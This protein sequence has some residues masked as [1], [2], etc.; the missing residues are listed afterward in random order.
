MSSA[1]ASLLLPLDSRLAPAP[2]SQF[3]RRH[4]NH[5]STGTGTGT[6]TSSRG[7]RRETVISSAHSNRSSTVSAEQ[8]SASAFD[9]LMLTNVNVVNSGD[10]P[11]S[12][13]ISNIDSVVQSVTNATKR[14]SQI[15][16]ITNNS[17]KKRKTQNRVGPWKLGRTL[18]RGSTG[19]VRLAKNVHTGKLA[20]VKIVP[21]SNFKKLENPKYKRDGQ[22]DRLPYGIEREIIIM[23]LILHPNIMGLYDVWENK[24]DLYL[25]L[26][27]IEGGELFDYLIKRGKLN[28]LEAINYFKQ[29]INGISYLHQFNICHRD[30]KPE[31]LLLDFDKVIKIADFGMAALEVREKLLETSCGSPHYA[32]PEIVAGKNYHGAP[33]DIW[34]CGIILFAL[35]TGHLP[36][37][38][39]NIR[40][41]LI[42]VQNGKFLMPPELSW[43]A[44]DLISKMLK[45]NP[46]DRITIDGILK[47]PLLTKYP[48]PPQPRSKLTNNGT[49]L[50][51]ID[52]KR[53]NLKPID[54]VDL[55]DKEILKNL[56]VLFHNCDEQ[57]IIKKLLSPANCSEK[58]FYFLLMK[59]RNEHA[60]SPALPNTEDGFPSDKNQNQKQPS[61]PKSASVTRTTLVDH[62]TGDLKTFITSPPLDP[63]PK[64]PV[65]TKSAGYSPTKL[66]TIH[67][68]HQAKT[69]H[70]T[71][72]VTTNHASPSKKIL[73]N[74]TNTVTTTASPTKVKDPQG[75]LSFKASNSFNK[76]KIVMKKTGST[77]TL[78]SLVN[79]NVNLL[80]AL[81]SDSEQKNEKEISTTETQGHQQQKGEAQDAPPTK[82]KIARDMTSMS[83][84]NFGRQIEDILEGREHEELKRQS[85]VLL[86]KQKE[87]LAKLQGHRNVTEPI[88]N[89]GGLS[90]LDPRQNSL[91][92]A[93]TYTTPSYASLK[94]RNEKLQDTQASSV[95]HKLGIDLKGSQVLRL[96]ELPD[97]I[98]D[99]K[100]DERVFD[101]TKFTGKSGDDSNKPK[102]FD[103]EVPLAESSVT[104]EPPAAPQLS[105]SRFSGALKTSSSRN[106]S[107]L[108]K[109]LEGTNKESQATTS[110]ESTKGSAA[111]AN[112]N[113]IDLIPNVRFSRFSMTKFLQEAESK[114]LMTSVPESTT[115]PPIESKSHLR[116]S[117][118]A[119]HE[120]QFVVVSSESGMNLAY[121]DDSPSGI[122]L[123]SETGTVVHHHHHSKSHLVRSTLTSEKKQDSLGLGIGVLDSSTTGAIASTTLNSSEYG[124]SF[125][126]VQSESL[127]HD[128][129]TSR[130]MANVVLENLNSTSYGP[131]MT[132]YN[133]SHHSKNKSLVEMSH[134][135]MSEFTNFD[136]VS[137][138]NI[139][140]GKLNTSNP[141]VVSSNNNSREYLDNNRNANDS[142]NTF[143]YQPTNILDEASLSESTLN[144][145]KNEQLHSALNSLSHTYNEQEEEEEEEDDEFGDD[146]SD[147]DL[148][149]DDLH[150]H[151]VVPQFSD[152]LSFTKKSGSQQI[153]S[154]QKLSLELVD[155]EKTPPRGGTKGVDFNKEVIVVD[156]KEPL[157]PPVSIKK[158]GTKASTI[159]R[160]L[161]LK[162]KRNAPPKPQHLMAAGSP[163]T[164]ISLGSSSGGSENGKKTNRF[165]RISVTSRVGYDPNVPRKTNWF[166]K[167]FNSLTNSPHSQEMQSSEASPMT[168][169]SRGEDLINLG[170][171]YSSAPIMPTKEIHSALASEELMKVFRNHLELKLME[172]TISE[173]DIDEEFCVITGVI[174]SLSAFGRNLKFKIDVLDLINSCVVHVFKVKGSSK[175]FDT[176]YNILAYLVKKA[177]IDTQG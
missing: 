21:K 92:R 112:N 101:D 81:K 11:D 95:L 174:P 107:Q 128:T 12:A 27:Y 51:S 146:A 68:T 18:G 176:L 62:L 170:T 23:K 148:T 159:F 102:D 65:P 155:N 131:V 166:K 89:T 156:T 37:D 168:L 100:N 84:F 167:F 41:L 123:P 140:V 77:R 175:S 56:S 36:F 126:N 25:I 90:S 69:P 121:Q 9:A 22:L 157:L 86:E 161:S 31:N 54:S 152:N 141:R 134:T 153:F 94:R 151:H 147:S 26:E 129:T 42:K 99:K 130:L 109:P 3:A 57:T 115:P 91:L 149:E 114:S 43:E 133:M 52:F 5:N 15:S 105:S 76:R 116:Q 120:E 82:E 14:L 34:S 32:S 1:T 110:S 20:A 136:I 88:Y 106:L 83:I 79:E 119:R 28:E 85:I 162:A 96:S 40:N 74:I 122:R 125:T 53:I 127:N 177:E 55:I 63:P 87:A 58:M 171:E 163:R 60:V 19:R 111:A 16:T 117:S 75:N 164:P 98:E 70:H 61:L 6:G 145:S 103:E 8:G 173:V 104:L 66:V 135:N 44:K 4:P 172:G 10:S 150:Q 59:Y 160:K 169:A 73:S 48:D 13:N 45:V 93:K 46:N 142:E 67:P 30:L 49:Y 138:S 38:D 143:T 24:N 50:N 64:Q 132:L 7:A 39:E 137:S 108:L 118:S 97:L 35:L 29:I 113:K 80:E 139:Q 33:S 78:N 17:T 154:T 144:E 165:S 47:H 124:D 2:D 72:K 71:V 158:E